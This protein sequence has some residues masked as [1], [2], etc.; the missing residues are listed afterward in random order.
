MPAGNADKPGENRVS[1]DLQ[2]KKKTSPWRKNINKIKLQNL[3]P[4]Q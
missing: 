3:I 4:E 2:K 1:P